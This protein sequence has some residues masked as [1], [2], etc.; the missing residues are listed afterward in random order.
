MVHL[1]F[2]SVTHGQPEY[3]LKRFGENIRQLSPRAEAKILREEDSWMAKALGMCSKCGKSC[4]ENLLLTSWM[5]LRS[6]HK[7]HE[8]PGLSLLIFHRWH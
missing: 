1:G 5:T 4:G 7:F 3:D 6:C 8:L 2:K